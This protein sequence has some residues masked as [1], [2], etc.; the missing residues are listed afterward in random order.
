MAEHKK[1]AALNPSAPTD[2]GQLPKKYMHSIA[3]NPVTDNPYT[4]KT[5][6]EIEEYYRL[7]AQMHD[8]DYLYMMDMDTLMEKTFPVKEA[9]ID[10][11]LYK[12]VYLFAGAPK[13]GKSFLVL[14]IAY[15]ISTGQPLWEYPVHPGPV[16]YLALEDQYQRLQERM[17]RMFGVDGKGD[18]LLAVT[19]KQIGQ[20][21]EKQMGYFLKQYPNARLIIIDTL[22]KVREAAG[23]RY[24]YASD[25]EIIGQLKTFADHH[26]ICILIVH[27][28][29]KQQA[30]DSFEMISG[31]TGLLGCA[32]GALLL[33]KEKR[34][35]NRA[36]LDVV[37]RDQ[38]DQRLRLL[39]N[40]ET[41]AWMFES[42]D[43]E[44]WKAPPD[45][46]LEQ[47]A[48]LVT[49]EQPVWHGT[50]TELVALLPNDLTPIGV[51]KRLNSRASRL[52]ADYGIRY[53]TRRRHD[54]RSLTLT[55]ESSQ[56]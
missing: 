49:P 47:V 31:T 52:Y 16:L 3:E 34:T 21:L 30:E 13:I 4:E 53:E 1:T 6:Q 20:G 51:V 54:G 33:Y 23:D 38:P 56:A 26:N 24:S 32:D 5:T 14:Q 41:L 19:A 45:P 11:L 35:D 2:G 17:A 42:A 36:I 46:L 8:P 43:R 25:Y 48:R 28:T 12:G 40:E 55:L 9:V 29:R 37:G 44:L 7:F 18:L 10:H 22:Q 15:A 27:H 39:R 50:A